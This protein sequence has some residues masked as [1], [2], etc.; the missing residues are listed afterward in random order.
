MLIC[1]L[2]REI[3]PVAAIWAGMVLHVSISASTSASKREV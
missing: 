2:E 3:F 1:F